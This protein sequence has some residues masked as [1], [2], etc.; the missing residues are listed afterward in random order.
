MGNKIDKRTIKTKKHLRSCLAQLLTE[1]ELSKITI[2]ELTE[3]AGIHRA[4]FYAHYEDIYELYQELLE[5][6]F[7]D[8]QKTLTDNDIITYDD[9]YKSI[10]NYIDTHKSSCQMMLESE[11]LR[12]KLTSFFIDGCIHIWQE[13]NPTLTITDEL[14]FF[15]YY[16]V[17]GVLSLLEHWMNGDITYTLEKMTKYISELDECVDQYMLRQYRIVQNAGKR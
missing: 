4:T 7:A 14:K 16:R 9:F 8:M 10:I 3:Y 12:K 15:S 1:N 5:T 11:N 13:E 6:F 17:C 2:R